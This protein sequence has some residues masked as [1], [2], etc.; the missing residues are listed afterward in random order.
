MSNISSN[1]MTQL[2][3]TLRARNDKLCSDAA[4]EIEH[5]RDLLRRSWFKSAESEPGLQ[6]EVMSYFEGGPA[7][8]TKTSPSNLQIDTLYLE[9][10]G[11]CILRLVPESEERFVGLGVGSLRALQRMVQSKL[12]SSRSQRVA[13]G[14]TQETGKDDEAR[15]LY[16]ASLGDQHNLHILAWSELNEVERNEWR[17]RA[18]KASVD[19]QIQPPTPCTGCEGKPEFPNIPCSICGMYPDGTSV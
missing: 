18:E 11:D 16:N 13:P 7:P 5:L 14:L 4:D 10:I 8:E 12:D 6:V 1:E 3:D 19:R 2:I 15:K 9:E 17:R